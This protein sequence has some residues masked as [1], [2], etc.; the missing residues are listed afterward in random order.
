MGPSEPRSPATASSGYPNIPEEQV[1]DLKYHL[2]KMLETFKE[3]I[4]KSPKEI[5]ENIIK[6]RN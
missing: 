4:N 5:E 6:W 2:M 1:Y 3:N